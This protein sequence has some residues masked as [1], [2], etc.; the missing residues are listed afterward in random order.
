MSTLISSKKVKIR[1]PHYCFGCARKFPKGTEMQYN[2]IVDDDI[3]NTYICPTCL[4]VID[5]MEYGDEFCYGDLK[6]DA[7]ELEKNEVTE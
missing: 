5:S 2:T 1:K 4:D 7:L 3:F 6:E